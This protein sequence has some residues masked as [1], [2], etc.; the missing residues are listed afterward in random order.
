M[1]NLMIKADNFDYTEWQRK[2]FDSMTTEEIKEDID[3]YVRAN[4]YNGNAVCI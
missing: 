4:P 2:Y 3:K 1:E